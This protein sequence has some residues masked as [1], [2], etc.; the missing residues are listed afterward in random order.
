MSDDDVTEIFDD[1]KLLESKMDLLI[2]LIKKSKHCVIYTGAGIS[3]S[4]GI[5]VRIPLFF[6]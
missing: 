3:T 4:A 2:N 6:C 5:P 1:E